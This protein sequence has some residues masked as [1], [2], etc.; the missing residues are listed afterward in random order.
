MSANL[1]AALAAFQS[2]MPTVKK[3]HKASVPTKA[4]GSYSSTYADLADVGLECQRKRAGY[5]E[6]P[7]V[8]CQFS[9][10]DFMSFAGPGSLGIQDT[11]SRR[12]GMKQDDR[13]TEQYK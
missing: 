5:L 2:E 8:R 7:R 3:S 1:A 9:M 11:A 10:T 13:Q 12:H 4:G 6:R